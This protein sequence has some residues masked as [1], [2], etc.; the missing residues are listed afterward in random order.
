MTK[1][2]NAT[3]KNLRREY[4]AAIDAV[5]KKYGLDGEMGK[6]T[7]EDNEF[8]CKLTVCNVTL[9]QATMKAP[10]KS[11]L[12][13]TNADSIIGRS[14]KLRNSIYTIEKMLKPGVFIGVTQRGKR[15]K[16]A[17]NVLEHMTLV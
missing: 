15:Y 8:R 16:I 6:I 1:F 10:M 17:A 3:I 13:G 9:K 4:Q 2:D 11:S 7:Y 14:Y 5:S 12:P